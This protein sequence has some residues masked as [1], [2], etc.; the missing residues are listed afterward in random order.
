MFIIITSCLAACIN[1]L[2][3][4]MLALIKPRLAQNESHDELVSITTL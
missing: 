3:T 2:R 1:Y 4:V